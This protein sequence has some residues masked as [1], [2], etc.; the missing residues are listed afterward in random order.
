MVDDPR[1]A[2]DKEKGV[3]QI[4]VTPEMIEA[5]AQILEDNYDASPSEA[6]DTATRVFL[7]MTSRLRG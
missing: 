2:G 5:G 4:E 3:P 7:A 1:Q 6:A